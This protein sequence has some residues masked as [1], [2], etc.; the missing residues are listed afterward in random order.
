MHK[1]RLC[2]VCLPEHTHISAEAIFLPVCS[3]ALT[4]PARVND[5]WWTMD[6]KIVATVKGIVAT[7]TDPSLAAVYFFGSAA[8]GKTGPLSDIDIAILLV[9]DFSD[10]D[11]LDKQL[12]LQAKFCRGLRT[13]QVDVVI[14]NQASPLLAHRVLSRGR[15]LFSRSDRERQAFFVK[16]IREYLDTEPLRREGRNHLMARIKEN[17]FAS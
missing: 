4:P 10:R 8:A 3:R 15:L 7:E 13:D 9:D 5:Y 12:E 16:T 2:R 1:F 14:L 11:Y 17:R 6:S